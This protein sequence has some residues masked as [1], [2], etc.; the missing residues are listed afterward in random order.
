MVR[1]RYQIFLSYNTKSAEPQTT[2]NTHI[3]KLNI[4]PFSPYI[5]VSEPFPTFFYIDVVV[6]YFC[7]DVVFHIDVAVIFV[8][9]TKFEVEGFADDHQLY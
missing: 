8:T 4:R 7:I 6:F 2:Y 3:L 5:S 1:N 9:E